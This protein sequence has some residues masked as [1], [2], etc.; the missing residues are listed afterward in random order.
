[1]NKNRKY[2]T[3]YTG[4]PVKCA[5]IDCCKLATQFVKAPTNSYGYLPCCDNDNHA[6]E[7]GSRWVGTET[8][9]EYRNYT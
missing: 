8:A 6:S 1:M 3:D 9:P 2:I 4:K 5:C 7:L